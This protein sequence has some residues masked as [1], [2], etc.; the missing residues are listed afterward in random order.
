MPGYP[1]DYSAIFQGY[2]DKTLRIGSHACQWCRPPHCRSEID[3][4]HLAYRPSKNHLP[5]AGPAPLHEE[6]PRRFVLPASAPARW[7]DSGGL[8]RPEPG[9]SSMG[10]EAP[11]GLDPS[12]DS[13]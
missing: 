3:A 8:I 6:T 13:R 5:A 7:A 11:G 4:L 1:G 10:D 12:A 9:N 2:R